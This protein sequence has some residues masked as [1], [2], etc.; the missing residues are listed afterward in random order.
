MLAPRGTMRGKRS[1]WFQRQQRVPRGTPGTFVTPAPREDLQSQRGGHGIRIG[2]GAN[3]VVR[4]A[5]TP[6]DLRSTWNARSTSRCPRSARIIEACVRPLGLRSCAESALGPSSELRLAPKHARSTWNVRR[7]ELLAFHVETSS[8]A[9]ASLE[10]V[11][12]PFARTR[13]SAYLLACASFRGDRRVRRGCGFQCQ[14]NSAPDLEPVS[15]GLLLTAAH[16]SPRTRRARS[17]WNAPF[18]VGESTSA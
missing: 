8:P 6:E 4:V 1:V 17:T 9:R 15:R 13:S 3:A 2:H 10:A 14:Q 11:V 12:R 5:P 16:R 18:F 7:R